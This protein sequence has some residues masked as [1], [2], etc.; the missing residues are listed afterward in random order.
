MP[1]NQTANFEVLE[2]TADHILLQ[3]LGP[4]NQYMTITNAAETVVA[5]VEKQYGIGKRRLLYYDSEDELTEL[6]VKDGRFAGF[7]PGGS[8]Q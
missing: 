3:D 1:N 7:A 8:K 6:R 4:W 5:Q 2:N